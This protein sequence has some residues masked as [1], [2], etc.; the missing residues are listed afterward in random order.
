MKENFRGHEALVADINRE[1]LFRYIVKASVV[2]DPF[3]NV[4]FVLAELLGDIGANVAEFFFDG[5]KNVEF[6]QP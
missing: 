4:G 5:L 1:G 3:F 2:F 6:H